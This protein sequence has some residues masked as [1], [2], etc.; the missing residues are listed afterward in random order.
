M[1]LRLCATLFALTS[2]LQASK[3]S[4]QDE[5]KEVADRIPIVSPN[6]R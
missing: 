5:P 2:L 6:T 4:A 1:T 3:T